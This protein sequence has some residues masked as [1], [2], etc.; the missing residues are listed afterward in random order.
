MLEKILMKGHFNLLSINVASFTAHN[1]SNA[2]QM[3]PDNPL[4]NADTGN[5]ASPEYQGR[6]MI[7]K[8]ITSS[9]RQKDDKDFR[10]NCL[11][12]TSDQQRSNNNP[13]LTF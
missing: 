8:P 5:K 9:L 13:L 6:P 1:S 2:T 12:L 10:G 4:H 11:D 3:F 7:V